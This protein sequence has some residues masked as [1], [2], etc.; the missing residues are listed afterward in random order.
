MFDRTRIVTRHLGQRLA[1]R[2]EPL[3]V[4]VWFRYWQDYPI[5]GREAGWTARTLHEVGAMRRA[6][7]PR[8]DPSVMHLW[9]VALAVLGVLIITMVCAF[10]VLDYL[11]PRSCMTSV[12]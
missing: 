3:G 8:I 7:R 9:A 2:L 12:M 5:R 4:E 1:A 6:L 10:C 11:I